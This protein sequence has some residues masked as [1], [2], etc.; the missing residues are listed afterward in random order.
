MAKYKV[1]QDTSGRYLVTYVPVEAG[2]YDVNIK[3]NG[4]EIEGT[5][6]QLVVFVSRPHNPVF[7]TLLLSPAPSTV[8]PRTQNAIYRAC[9]LARTLLLLG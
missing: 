3:W 6:G 9:L 8:F 4:Y 2:Q 1:D 5:T 7:H